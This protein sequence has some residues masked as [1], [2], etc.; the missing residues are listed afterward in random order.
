MP[1]FTIIIFINV[2]FPPR[3]IS[4][5][6]ERISLIGNTDAGTEANYT[7]SIS[8]LCRI[9]PH[10]AYSSIRPPMRSRRRIRPVGCRQREL[11][12]MRLSA[13]KWINLISSK[14]NGQSRLRIWRREFN[15]LFLYE[16]YDGFFGLVARRWSI[17]MDFD[18]IY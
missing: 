8:P 6:D 14:R 13:N 15:H 17:I 12:F 2:T 4:M 11:I 16:A 7:E 5:A 1:P 10:P 9:P 3:P 18:R